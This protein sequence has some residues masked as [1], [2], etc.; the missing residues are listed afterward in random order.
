MYATL[1]TE[2]TDKRPR[3]Y[4]NSTDKEIMNLGDALCMVG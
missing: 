2:L 4:H 3:S 1:V